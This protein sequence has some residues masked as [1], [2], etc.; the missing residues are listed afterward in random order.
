MAVLHV[1]G[2]GASSHS[3]FRGIKNRQTPPFV[4]YILETD[5]P[6]YNAGISREF[7]AV[8]ISDKNCEPAFDTSSDMHSTLRSCDADV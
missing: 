6:R 7:D 8:T 4:P 2:H 5:R 1:R 3:T